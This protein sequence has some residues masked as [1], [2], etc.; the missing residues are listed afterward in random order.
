MYGWN[1]QNINL[2]LLYST[3]DINHRELGYDNDNTILKYAVSFLYTLRTLAYTW[4]VANLAILPT[5]LLTLK[6]VQH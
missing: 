2:T 5:K 6:T 3:K 4:S 1:E